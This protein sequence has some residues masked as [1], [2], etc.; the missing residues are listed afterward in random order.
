MS[1]VEALNEP[2]ELPNEAPPAPDVDAA[3]DA[4]W[5]KHFT[6]NGAMRG[7]DGKFTSPNPTEPEAKSAEDAPEEVEE[8]VEASELEGADKGEEAETDGSTLPD[9]TVPLPANWRGKEAVW[10]KIPADVKS[11]IY[12]HEQNLHKTLSEQGSKLGQV[13]PIIDTVEQYRSLYEGRVTADG[14]QATAKDAVAYLFDAQAKLDNPQTRYHT[15]MNIIDSYGAREEVYALLTGQKQLPQNVQAS[16]TPQDIESILD[17]KLAADRAEREANELVSRLASDKPL[18]NSIPEQTMV[19][20]INQAWN[21][22]GPTADQKAVFDLAYDM[23]VN[24]DPDLRAKAQAARQAAIKPKP[25]NAEGARRANSVNV[26]STSSSKPAKP[27]IDQALDE[28][29]E[30]HYRKA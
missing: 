24:A 8:A 6:N 7:E 11:E 2:I 29:W 25:V 4:V 1:G 22:L 18:Y 23:A 13:K 9:D 14:R 21:K 19:L 5:D 20:M 15:L 27:T 26:T 3:L 10:A 28:V 30:K 16:I 17:K 12:E